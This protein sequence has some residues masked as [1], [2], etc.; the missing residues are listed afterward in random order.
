MTNVLTEHH[1]S[2]VGRLGRLREKT[3][4]KTLHLVE[5]LR[6]EELPAIPGTVDNTAKVK[7]PWGMLLN[8]ELGDCVEAAAIHWRQ[9]VSAMAGHE[10]PGTDALAEQVYEGAAGYK[11][12]DPSTDQGTVELDMMNY[13]RHVGLDGDKI[14]GF[15]N[16]GLTLSQIKTAIFLFGGVIVGVNL[17]LTAESEFEEHK[18]WRIVE[19]KGNGAPGSWGGHGIPLLGYT[20]QHAKFPTWGETAEMTWGFWNTYGAEAWAPLSPDWIDQGTKKA[21]NGLDFEA[22]EARLAQFGQ[23]H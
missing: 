15:V 9:A 3:D 23:A 4:A 16:V 21:P 6:P 1:H 17:P 8:D 10:I 19:R 14:A 5:F 7:S 11:A 2:H 18:T 20:S 12:G 22:L 13:W